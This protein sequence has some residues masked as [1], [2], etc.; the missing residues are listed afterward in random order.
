MKKTI[1]VVTSLLA[2]LALIDFNGYQSVIGNN[3]A[4]LIT[5]NFGIVN[6]NSGTIT[7]NNCNYSV[8]M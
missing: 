6:S 4:G 3:N 2:L 1:R 7:K 8:A 5:K